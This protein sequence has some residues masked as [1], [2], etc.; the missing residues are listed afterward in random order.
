MEREALRRRLLVRLIDAE[1]VYRTGRSQ[2]ELALLADIFADDLAGEDAETIDRAFA[3][4]RRGSTRFPTPAHILAIIP[5]CR[6][7]R[8]DYAALPMEGEGT[9]TPGIGMVVT[10]ALRGD[11]EAR[12]KMARLMGRAMGVQAVRQ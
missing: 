9:R 1:M 2:E 4:H 11:M 8:H 7:Q 12:E 5:Q 6:A 3:A 10:R